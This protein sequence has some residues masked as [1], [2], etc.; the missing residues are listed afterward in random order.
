MDAVSSN[1]FQAAIP[2]REGFVVGRSGE[3]NNKWAVLSEVS[4][5]NGAGKWVINYLNPLER[6]LTLSPT[7]RISRIVISKIL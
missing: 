5:E 6:E 2:N 7:R 4:E 1:F 3:E